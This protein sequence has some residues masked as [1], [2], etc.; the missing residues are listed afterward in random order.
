MTLDVPF[1]GAQAFVFEALRLVYEIFS[2]GEVSNP[3][4]LSGESWLLE[5]FESWDLQICSGIRPRS[6]RERERYQNAEF[7]H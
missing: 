1:L 4:C 6:E 2:G 5:G 3:C 7:A